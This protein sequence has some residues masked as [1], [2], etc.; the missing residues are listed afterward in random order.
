MRILK[1]NEF[2]AKNFKK[3]SWINEADG[4]GTSPFLLKKEGDNYHYFFKLDSEEEDKVGYHLNIGKYSNLEVVPGAK[5]SYC[6]MN[7][8]EVSPEIIE[9]IAI[10]KSELPEMGDGEFTASGNL[11]SRLMEV[12]S[13]CILNYL[14]SNPKVVRIYDEIQENLKYKDEKGSYLEF[15]KSIVISYLGE[16]W[17]VQEGSTKNSI[18]ISR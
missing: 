4:F 3:N 14:E 2:I 17:K 7:M 6:V 13:K 10:E 12:A 15:M 9:D 16:N 11:I 18:L 5:N 1:L 8:N